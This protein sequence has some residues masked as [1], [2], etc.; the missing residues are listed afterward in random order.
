MQKSLEKV[1]SFLKENEQ[2]TKNLIKKLCLIPAPS[3]SEDNR[4]LF[5]KNYLESVGAKNVY[6]D[7]AKNCVYPVGDL[8]GEI[9]LFL[10]HTDTVFS[11]TTET[12][13]FEDGEYAYSPGICDNTVS[14]AQMLTVCK[15]IASNGLT[16][17]GVG[18]L[19]VF[20]SCEE[21]MGNLKG[22][23]HIFSRYKNKIV[24]AYSFD[25]RYDA[26][27]TKCVGS[28]RYKITVETEGGHSFNAFGNKNAI[29]VA[30]KLITELYS[31]KIPKLKGSKTTYNVG[32][33]TGGTSVNTI[34]QKA[35]FL[36]EYRSDNVNCL[37][38]MQSTF[39]NV[40]NENKKDNG[41]KISVELVGERPCEK[42]VNLNKLNE[43]INRCVLVTEKYSGVKCNLT[44]GSTDCNIPASLGVPAV[45]VGSFWGFGMHTREEKLLLSS[46]IIGLNIVAETVI[47]YFNI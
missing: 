42:G 31:V 4:A 8:T 34:A 17:N 29:C 6:I 26:L 46:V 35:E 11:D 40:I 37:T 16:P 10:A 13:Y 12:P 38:L 33:I 45:C 47:Y 30:S 15:F 25:G 28:H 7:E 20:N 32:V 3:G 39:L 44:S 2:E 14:V 22:V 21:G 41:V 9:I 18:V 5:C 1:N 43:V 27:V 19:F 23:K 36:Y 24:T